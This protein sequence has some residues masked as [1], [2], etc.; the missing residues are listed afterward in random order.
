MFLHIKGSSDLSAEK[1][2]LL[3]CSSPPP[4][5]PARDESRGDPLGVQVPQHQHGR[6]H[7]HMALKRAIN[8]EQSRKKKKRM[9]LRERELKFIF[10]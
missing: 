10:K 8:F 1:G 9:D 6:L 5:I 2:I 4:P 3:P 7:G